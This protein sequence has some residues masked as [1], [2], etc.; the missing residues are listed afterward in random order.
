MERMK[1]QRRVSWGLFLVGLF[2]VA[3]GADP[4]NFK[5]C[6]CSR[7]DQVLRIADMRD[8]QGLVTDYEDGT[9]IAGVQIQLGD[10]SA[11]TDLAGMFSFAD[12]AFGEH[13]FT[14]SKVGFLTEEFHFDLDHATVLPLTFRFRMVHTMD[15]MVRDTDVS[16]ESPVDNFSHE[17]ELHVSKKGMA[18]HRAFLMFSKEGL[19]ENA[20]ILSATLRTFLLDEVNDMTFSLCHISEPWDH[21][22][23][24]WI[25]QPGTVDVAAGPHVM[26]TGSAG[27]PLSF[28]VTNYV[29]DPRFQETPSGSL[30]PSF[31]VALFS[32]RLLRAHVASSEHPQTPLRVEVSYVLGTGD[33]YEEYP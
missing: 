13:E 2:V 24:N 20:Q 1:K 26:L 32:D 4:I 15:L 6:G 11:T 8:F 22:R 19:P 5:R 27:A 14:A 25:N 16:A 21:Q 9:P 30:H 12:L 31:G 3:T 17:P 10:L 29:R 7:P 23:V 33:G 18:T 28:D